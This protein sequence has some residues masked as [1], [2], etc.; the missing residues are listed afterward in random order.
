[1]PLLHLLKLLLLAFLNLL[2][3]SRVVLL[4]YF[5]LLLH[6]LLLDL[7]TFAILLLAQILELL[8]VLLFEPRI[9]WLTRC[10]RPIVASAWIAVVAPA[11]L[12][13]VIRDG[14]RPIRIGWR[15]IRL[16]RTILLINLIRRIRLVRLIW[17]VDRGVLI[18]RIPLIRLNRVRLNLV[19]LIR[20]IHHVFL[21]LRRHLACG[22]RD[23]NIRPRGL[24]LHLAFLRDGHWPSA[25]CL[26]RL[27]LPCKRNRRGRRS[28]SCYHL[29]VIKPL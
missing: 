20:A 5:L 12:N 4:L 21:I 7:L 1:M 16:N 10:G 24:R 28:S 17:T 13:V 2:L 25:I 11:V 3:I 27:L 18:W 22:R 29:P 6:L 15:L 9:L 19:R 14:R 8:L 23:A 26:N